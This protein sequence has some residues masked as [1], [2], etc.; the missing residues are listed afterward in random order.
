[1]E[2]TYRKLDTELILDAYRAGLFPMAEDSYDNKIFWVNP[3]VRG[4][5][6]LDKFHIS[7]SLRKLLRKIMIRIYYPSFNRSSN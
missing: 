3:E 5:I 4:I 6:P 2:S 7:R 1:M